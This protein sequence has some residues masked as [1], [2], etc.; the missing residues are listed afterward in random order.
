MQTTLRIDDKLYREAKAEA[1]RQ[2]LTITRFLE[3]ALQAR[4]QRAKSTPRA[5]H[6]FRVHHSQET[7]N[8]PW[9]DILRVAEEEQLNH[10]ATKLGIRNPTE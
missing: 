3:E 8:R 4:L 6:V 5:P 10:D 9:S 7:E 1:A 2:G